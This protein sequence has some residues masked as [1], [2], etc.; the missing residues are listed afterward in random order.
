MNPKDEP[1][2]GRNL[3]RR[4]LIALG[5]ASTAI[6]SLAGLRVSR[7]E[8]AGA[9]ATE[10]ARLTA[11]E[12][13]ALIRERKV[14]AL[15]VTNAC[16]A[17][18]EQV[19]PRLNAVVSSRFDDARRDAER[20]DADLARGARI[21]PLHGVPMTLKDSFDTA[22]LKS[23]YGTTGRA[24]FVPDADATV[25]AR[26]KAAGAI[27]LGKSNTPEFTWS[28][29]TNNLVFGRTN[30]PWDVS[31][32]PGGSSGGAAAIVAAQGVPFD[33]GTDTGGSIRVPAHFCGI[34]VL[35]PT[36]G[37][38]PRTG[39]AVGPEGH[40]QSLTH[41]GP[42]ARSVADLALLYDIIAGSDGRDPHV[43]DAPR[44]DYRSVAV[45]GLRI[46]V[47]T[48]NGLRTPAPSIAAAVTSV[49]NALQS[50]GA[51]VTA[52]LPPPLGEIIEIDDQ[53]Y[54]ADGYAWLHRLLER[55]GTTE[56]GPD[57]APYLAWEP[58]TPA[59]FSAA[60]ERWDT[61]R[62]RMLQWFERYD[63][64][65]CPVTAFDELAH[66]AEDAADAYPAFT[67]TYAYNMTGWPAAIVRAGTSPKGRPMG[68]QVIGRPWQ[69]H[70]VLAI[71]SEIERQFGGYQA[72]PG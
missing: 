24:T 3:T 72:P 32:S 44:P 18:I 23:T 58:L 5:A 48:D 10:L 33:I 68:V 63:A 41:V 67:Y 34:A 12:V 42:M 65:V 40:L 7:A 11:T 70:V 6:G 27:L 66:G 9:P 56:P 16:I 69:E 36:A 22:G 37:R 2:T 25:V 28:F 4:D 43:V 1:M 62:S 39:H 54:R 8:S 30:N 31:L 50:A 45:R 21:G 20:A 38:F 15:E 60:M 14:S 35:K 19:N 59:Q 64:I 53:I 71:A 49:A 55:A 61:W 52:D 29:E 47:H 46:A 17:R 26:L 13:A 57:V 51:V